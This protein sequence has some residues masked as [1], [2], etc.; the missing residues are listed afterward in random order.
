MGAG[1]TSSD[2]LLDV[3]HGVA[4]GLGGIRGQQLISVVWVALSL[5]RLWCPRKRRS[6][7][8]GN[9]N[10]EMEV[11]FGGVASGALSG[12]TTGKMSGLRLER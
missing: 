9:G 3:G 8:S 12:R 1:G 6:T 5:K 4:V 10:V 7:A 2:T 11:S